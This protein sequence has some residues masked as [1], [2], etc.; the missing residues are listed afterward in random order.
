MSEIDEDERREA[1]VDRLAALLVAGIAAVQAA[2]CDLAYTTTG[3][4]CEAYNERFVLLS[5]ALDRARS[6]AP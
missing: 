2:A 1:T 3:R 6:A 4:E 5:D